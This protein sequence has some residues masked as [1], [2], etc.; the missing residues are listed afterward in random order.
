MT[1][2]VTWQTFAIWFVFAMAH[3]LFWLWVYLRLGSSAVARRIWENTWVR[4]TAWQDPKWVLIFAIGSFAFIA[5]V[6]FAAIFPE[7]HH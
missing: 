3:S 7:T 5:F 1:T 2:A 4:W 6:V